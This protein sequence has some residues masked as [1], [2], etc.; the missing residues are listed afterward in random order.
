MFRISSEAPI[1]NA[2]PLGRLGPAPRCRHAYSY[3]GLCGL[4]AASAP[5]VRRK[6]LGFASGSWALVPGAGDSGSQESLQPVRSPEAAAESDLSQGKLR[7]NRSLSFLSEW[8]G[9]GRLG[10]GVAG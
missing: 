9:K 6:R 10:S 5:K 3:L 1:S 8:D 7:K 4:V 2:R